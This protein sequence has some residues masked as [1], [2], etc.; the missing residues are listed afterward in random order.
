MTL[1]SLKSLKRSYMRLMNVL[2]KLSRSWLYT[3]A[4]LI[5]LKSSLKELRKWKYQRS[6]KQPMLP[7]LRIL[8]KMRWHLRQPHKRL[9]PKQ[10]RK[11]L[12]RKKEVRKRAEEVHLKRKA[13]CHRHPKMERRFHHQLACLQS[14]PSL[15]QATHRQKE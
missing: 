9:A 11:K 1:G 8:S 13:T 6:Q 2:T 5:Y 3:R 14:R 10:R 15:Y 12:M 4:N 7:A